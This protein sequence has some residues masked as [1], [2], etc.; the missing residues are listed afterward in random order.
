MQQ[1]KQLFVLMKSSINILLECSGA[2]VAAGLVEKP[3]RPC[4]PPFTPIMAVMT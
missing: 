3:L 2:A 4:H 1:Y